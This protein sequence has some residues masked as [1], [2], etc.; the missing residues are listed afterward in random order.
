MHF[1]NEIKYINQ[2]DLE[3]ALIN[4]IVFLEVWIASQQVELVCIVMSGEHNT[5]QDTR[6]ASSQ[7]PL[8]LMS[9]NGYDHIIQNGRLDDLTP[10]L[11]RYMDS[12]I[13]HEKKHLKK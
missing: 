2:F 6:R 5:Y 7:P 8:G 10:S 3:I 1:I 4:S 13:D 11:E 9:N 12:N